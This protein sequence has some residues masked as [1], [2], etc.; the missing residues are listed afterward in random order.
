MHLCCR[1]KQKPPASENLNRVPNPELSPRMLETRPIRVHA[2]C[3][4]ASCSTIRPNKR[5]LGFGK[6][7]EPRIPSVF[8]AQGEVPFSPKTPRP[9]TSWNWTPQTHV[10]QHPKS[11]CRTMTPEAENRETLSSPPPST[12][13]PLPPPPPPT[14]DQ[15]M[16][17]FARLELGP[18]Q[19]HIIF[20]WF[21]ENKGTPRRQKKGG[22]NSGE[23][24]VSKGT[25]Q[26]DSGA[27]R[28]G[29]SPASWPRWPPSPSQCR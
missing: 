19:K 9:I 28:P 21:V 5:K 15:K 22:A 7:K 18:L 10:L 2:A 16:S 26:S 29:S 13:P 11:C 25:R 23:V 3:W 6:F 24:W 4:K 12:P 27:G 14:A 20:G 8:K 17:H 1:V